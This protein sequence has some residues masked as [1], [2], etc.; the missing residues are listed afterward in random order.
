VAWHPLTHGD[1]AN[2]G[3]DSIVALHMPG[4]SP[5]HLVFWHEQ[6]RTAFTGDLVVSGSSVMIHAGRGGDLERYL[7]SLERLIALHPA[8][9]MPAHGP[10]VDD[11]LALVRQYIAHRLMREQQIL[12]ALAA[13]FDTVP[14]IAGSVYD[15]LAPALMPAARETVR[16]HLEK[17][18]REQRAVEEDGRWRRLPL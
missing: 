13:G 18:R 1:R 11:P 5:D 8:R 6:S 15:D 2:L 12:E 9:L 14:A 7:S 4:H 17:L 10:D 3:E 16:A